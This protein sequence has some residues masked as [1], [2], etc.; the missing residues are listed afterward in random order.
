LS[1]NEAPPRAWLR[2]DTPYAG[3]AD[4]V[5]ADIAR[6]AAASSGRALFARVR[7]SGHS[8]LI[9]K[10]APTGAP[11]AYVRP[12][13]LRAAT[14]SGRP[15]GDT[16]ASGGPVL[17]A[18]GG[19]DCVIAYDPK[20]WPSPTDPA[21]PASDIMLVDLLHQALAQLTG[22]AEP[23]RYQTGEAVSDI[24]AGIE[25]YRRERKDG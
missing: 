21:S 10:P 4:S 15:T 8:V 23:L 13:D 24:A 20:D 18:G 11:N 12:V 1:E 25:L 9:E 22:A 6:I 17:G 2:V 5:V 14:A 3:Y 7:A 16:D 19:S